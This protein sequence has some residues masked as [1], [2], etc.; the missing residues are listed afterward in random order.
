MLGRLLGH[1]QKGGPPQLVDA[2]GFC[3]SRAA[4]SSPAS[5]VGAHRFR[6]ACL[7]LRSADG[8][9]ALQLGL[10][11]GRNGELSRED[12]GSF[13]QHFRQASPY[14]IGHQ[15]STF[16]VVIPGEVRRSRAPF[17]AASLAVAVFCLPSACELNFWGGRSSLNRG[18]WRACS[19]TSPS[20]TVRKSHRR[21]PHSSRKRRGAGMASLEACR[22]LEKY[23]H[24]RLNV[25]IAPRLRGGSAHP[26]TAAC[27][28]MSA[29]QTKTAA[30][31][32]LTLTGQSA[33]F[34]LRGIRTLHI[35]FPVPL[36]RRLR[37][38]GPFPFSM[39]LRGGDVFLFAS[40]NV[41]SGSVL[42]FVGVA[43]SRRAAG[44]GSRDSVLHR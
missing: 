7:A 4:A 42:Y 33:G 6:H 44:G 13:V 41:F 22:V 9:P 12:Y 38:V 30:R 37:V 27:T 32:F 19:K 26:A 39:G 21:Q 17:R 34:Q 35:Q 15:G 8:R 1:P 10:P 40:F 25:R 2:T 16:V 11:D 18:C 31:F 23:L 29:W 24:H 14:I 36:A 43:S 20:C 5:S 28:M 3:P